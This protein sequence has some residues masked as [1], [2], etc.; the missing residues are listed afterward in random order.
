MSSNEL[1]GSKASPLPG[2]LHQARWLFL[3]TSTSNHMTD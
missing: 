2:Q 1:V 3:R